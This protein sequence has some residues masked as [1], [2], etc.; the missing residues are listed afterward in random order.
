MRRKLHW[1][2][3]GERPVPL[4]NWRT[5][6]MPCLR[7]LNTY[8]DLTCGAKKLDNAFRLQK[9]ATS[10][11]KYQVYSVYSMLVSTWVQDCIQVN[12]FLQLWCDLSASGQTEP[13][14]K[15]R[16]ENARNI[17]VLEQC[18]ES[19]IR[20]S[21]KS[22]TRRAAPNMCM[23]ESS[24]SQHFNFTTLTKSI[25]HTCVC[26]NLREVN[27][28]TGIFAT[29]CMQQPVGTENKDSYCLTNCCNENL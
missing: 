18:L 26:A 17:S 12:C 22:S 2:V 20:W 29:V 14:S 9:D 24:R 23:I 3:V 7:F 19:Q 27:R 25:R 16:R 15:E 5:H 4:N 11:V 6:W 13:T 21:R 8:V 10:T 1:Y 28:M